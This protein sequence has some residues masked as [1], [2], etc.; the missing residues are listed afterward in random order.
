MLFELQKAGLDVR[1]GQQTMLDAREVKSTDEIMLLNTAAS[2]VDGTY[3]MI[4]EML[5]P[6]VRESDIVAAANKMLYELGS[7][8]VE[9]IN[10]VAGERCSPHPHNFTDRLI[11]P[12]DQ[13]FFDIIQA[14]MGYRPVIT[15]LLMLAGQLTHN[16]MLTNRHVSGST[17][18]S[19]WCARA[20]VPIRLRRSSPKLKNLAFQAKWR[21]L[22]CS[23]AMAWAWPCMSGPLSAAWCRLNNPRKSRRAWYL[24]WKLI[25]RLRMVFQPREL[26]R[27][28]LS[29]TRVARS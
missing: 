19:P 20:W 16:V 15:G 7:D 14:Y 11:R 2:M 5:R 18:A 28:L 24:L 3:D 23:S 25:A 13:A 4:N 9:A 10:A 22:R 27:K 29:L 21:L 1:D 26:K 12:G 17:M 8:D 6:G